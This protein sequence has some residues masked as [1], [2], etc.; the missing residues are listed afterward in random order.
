M[1]TTTYEDVEEVAPIPKGIGWGWFL[2]SGI[3]WFFLGLA[4]LSLRPGT[5]AL[6]GYMVALV[7][8]LAGALELANAFMSDSWKWL[9]GLA[10]AIFIVVGVLSFTEPFQ[11]FIGLSILFGWFLIVK[12]M[13]VFVMSLAWRVPGSLWGLGVAVG[14]AYIFIGLWAIGYPGRSAWLLTL[15]I[16]IGAIFH[17]VAD[18]VTA[19]QVKGAR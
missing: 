12:G 14:L 10:G 11:T 4:I 6:I 1:A 2:T 17:G 18:L 19:F 7:V 15:W 13:V 8:I 9:H 5:I 3:I 16:G